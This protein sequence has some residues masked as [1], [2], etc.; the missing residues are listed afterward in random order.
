M[1]R[2]IDRKMAVATRE[3]AAAQKEK[4]VELK[5]RTARHTIDAAKTMAKMIDDEQA[6][7]NHREQELSHREAAVKEE[8]D[9]FSTLRTNLEARTHD[10]KVREAKVEGFLAEQHT[11]VERIVKWVG[12]AS[13]TLEPLGLS[14]IQ[15]AEAPSLLGAI[16]PALDSAAEHLQCLESTLVARLEAEGREL[17]RVVVNYVLTCFRSHDPAISLTPVLEGPVPEAET[18]A[19][20]GVQEV[21]EIVAARFERSTGPDL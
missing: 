12:E 9:C 11:G 14:P 1:H 21:V 17:A 20:E 15:V 4:E 13:T 2:V 16:L 10:L 5:E 19:R 6:T 18:A 7:L 3:K 8:E